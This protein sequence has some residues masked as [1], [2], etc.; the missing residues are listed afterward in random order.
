MQSGDGMADGS[1][2]KNERLIDGEEEVKRKQSGRSRGALRGM[3]GARGR[4]GRP[5]EEHGS[6]SKLH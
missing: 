3:G 6:R 2:R 5:G 4:E 1:R